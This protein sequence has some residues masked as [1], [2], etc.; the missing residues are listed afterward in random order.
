MDGYDWVTIDE[1]RKLLHPT[2][3]AC[4]DKVKQLFSR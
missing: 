1:A 2:Q 4:L 3:V